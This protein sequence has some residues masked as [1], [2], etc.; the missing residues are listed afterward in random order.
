MDTNEDYPFEDRVEYM[1]AL[2]NE[3]GTAHG[4]RDE[5]AWSVLRRNGC[6]DLIEKTYEFLHTQ[7]FPY[8][9]NVLNDYIHRKGVY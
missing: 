1:I 4:M 5:E 3:F 2:V 6:V 7:S 8:V 9:V